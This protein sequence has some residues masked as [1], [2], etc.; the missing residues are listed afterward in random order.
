MLNINTTLALDRNSLHR[1]VYG[2]DVNYKPSLPTRDEIIV[3][4]HEACEDVTHGRVYPAEQV[5]ADLRGE[6][7]L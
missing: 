6:F 7:K 5:H 4:F 3:K 2:D 1:S